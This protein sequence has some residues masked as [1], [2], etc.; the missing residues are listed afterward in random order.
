M[1]KKKAPIPQPEVAAA[2]ETQLNGD[3]SLL[4][5]QGADEIGGQDPN[6][7]ITFDASFGMPANDALGLTP[8]QEAAL[9][10]AEEILAE[11]A[12]KQRQAEADRRMA[13]GEVLKRRRDD[14]VTFRLASEFETRAAEDQAYYEGQDETPLSQYY[15]GQVPDAPL[16]R[17]PVE[18]Y[19]SKVF[20]NITRPYVETAA[21][22]VIEVLCPSD[23]S[24][25]GIAPARLPAKMPDLSATVMQA[26]MSMQQA[27]Q[28]EQAQQAQQM[29][30]PEGAGA[31]PPVPT[32]NAG[33]VSAGVDA[34]ALMNAEIA[35][36]TEKITAC[37]TATQ[38]WIDTRLQLCG[39]Q[40]A[41]REVV[42]D[43][44]RIGTGVLKGPVANVV[45]RMAVKTGDNGEMIIEAIKEILPA[46]FAI[47]AWNVYPDPAC[48]E[49]IHRGQY[50]V[51]RGTMVEREVLALLEDETY[52]K[53]AVMEAIARG[54]RSSAIDQSTRP[55]MASIDPKA[56]PFVIWHYTG[57]LG[58]EDVMAMGCPC[59]ETDEIE[60]IGVPVVVT[61]IGDIPVKASLNP[62]PSGRFPYDFL[63]WQRVAGSPFGM[64]VG[65]QV[66]PAQDVLNAN[67]RALNENGGLSSGPQIVLARNSVVPA[68]GKWEI[69]PR[70][71]WYLKPDAD[72][73]DVTKAFNSFVI[74][75][76]QNE[77]LSVIE[78]A[79]KMAETAT[80]L[81]VL[82]QGQVQNGVPET[83]GG[84]QIL[85]ANASSLLRRVARLIDDRLIVPH[86]GG[87]LEWARIYGED[88][89]L[90]E[91]F[92]VIPRGST[93]L[94]SRD[95]ANQFLL[96][97]VPNMIANPAF[98]IDPARWFKAIS[99]RN[100][101]DPAEIQFTKEELEKVLSAPPPPDPKVQV[102]EINKAA[103]E[104]TAQL[105]SQTRIAVAG[106]EAQTDRERTMRDTDRD[107]A[108]VALE[109]ERTR[110]TA[111]ARIAELQL[112]RELALLD[113]ASKHEL[114]LEDVKK[115]LAINGAKLDLQRELS[116]LPSPSEVGQIA[117]AEVPVP[118]QVVSPPSEPAQHAP[119]GQ[120]YQ[121]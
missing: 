104:S 5:M 4:I 57:F 21:G 83:V 3:N 33:E 86:I 9:A 39:F 99:R 115:E 70:K 52:V 28:Q 8:E 118:S 45:T 7:E 25:F 56:E 37:A 74:P 55:P 35:K 48:G 90:K 27:A 43:A 77:L 12:A 40:P 68:D 89:R 94:V 92:N 2:P 63:C 113:Y 1:A 34:N 88:P 91:E 76:V 69:T 108:Y 30:L 73:G 65:R 112:R 80:G 13:L 84:M 82:L 98:G 31:P 87:Y 105:E 20:L 38:D 18:Q 71:V 32:A 14:A 116:T 15:K 114:K 24:S 101:V 6:A 109:T 61:M 97:A 54:P 121:F 49:D 51:E 26:E 11:E 41:M 79:L 67:L 16:L 64:G 93:A 10:E 66:R 62:L 19:R 47:S 107:S 106:V 46:T 117:R 22:K 81:P 111:E 110:V 75:G 100:G 120:A 119:N 95:V 44:A 36:A 78:F 42:E 58:R 72:I 85:M 96:T 102:A 17:K 23:E 53:E 59:L 103:K 60:N 50:I 29:Q